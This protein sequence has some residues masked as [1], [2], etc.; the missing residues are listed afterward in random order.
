M[1]KEKI[2]FDGAEKQQ[3]KI[4]KVINELE[5][6]INPARGAKPKNSDIDGDDG[7]KVYHW[8]LRKILKKKMNDI[9][10][11]DIIKEHVEDDEDLKNIPDSLIRFISRI[12]LHI[13]K[14][15]DDA[16]N[17]FPKILERSDLKKKYRNGKND[18]N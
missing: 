17:E 8:M 16:F 4:F 6:R 9:K 15:K 10:N 2:T 1:Y 14:N 12:T 11:I 7:D 5:K 3:E 13:I 18:V